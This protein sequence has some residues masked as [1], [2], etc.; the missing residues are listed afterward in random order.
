M[1]KIISLK[2]QSQSSQPSNVSVSVSPKVNIISVD[3]SDNS[4]G[5]AQKKDI[6]ASYKEKEAET[7]SM[8]EYNKLKRY[9]EVL[10]T[11]VSMLQQN[12][13]KYN[14][15]IVADDVQLMKFIQL[16]TDA[17][18]VQMDAEDLGEGCMSRKTYRKVESIFVIKGGET[19][20]LKY[21]FPEVNKELKELGVSVKYV[22]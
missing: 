7:V 22:W 9:N 16:L 3:N 15:Y 13:L 4:I 5:G 11:L 18:D 20:N 8:E 12:P 17:D 19:K 21:D 6:E 14:G 2:K 10:K 1:S